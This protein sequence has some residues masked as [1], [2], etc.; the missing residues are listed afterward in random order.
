MN[1]VVCANVPFVVVQRAANRADE[2]ASLQAMVS[3]GLRVVELDEEAAAAWQ[4]LA[5]DTY[6]KVRGEL[7][8]EDM[9]DAVMALR[10]RY[11]AERD[12]NR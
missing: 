3:R 10:D 11:R 2:Q 4:Q 7:I 1:A 12:A 6:P 8:D 5:Q 9:F